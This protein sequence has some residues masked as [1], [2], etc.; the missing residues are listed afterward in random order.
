MSG[1]K[2]KKGKIIL[3]EGTDGSGKNTQARKLFDRLTEEKTPVK[4]MSFPRYETPTG[5]IIGECY[6]GKN[7]VPWFEEP[8]HLNPKIAS[9][10]YAA[11]RL[12]AKEEMESIINSGTNLILD[13][14]VE[15]NMAHQGGKLSGNERR[16]FIGWVENLEYNLN[17]MPRPDKTIF[18]YVPTSVAL[19]LRKSRENS[20]VH[21][22]SLEHL[23]NAEETYLELSER[24]R[25]TKITCA[26]NGKMRT[27][28][29]IAEEIYQNVSL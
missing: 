13:R 1:D 24:F 5:R 21:E 7:G 25:W 27:I 6:L 14:Y 15:S 16:R 23:K 11:D 29:N 9:L 10:Y 28:D 20:D 17:N 22:S 18:L 26:P 2:M 4:M 3:I 8:T 12:A 19:E